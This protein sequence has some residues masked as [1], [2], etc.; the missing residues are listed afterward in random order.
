MSINDI[1]RGNTKRYKF[2]FSTTAGVIDITGWKI[3]FTAKSDID[4]LDVNAEIQVVATAGDDGLD[5]PVNG[6]M[7]LTLTSTDTDQ[8]PD[9]YHYEFTRVIPG[10]TPD[11]VQLDTGTFSILKSVIENAV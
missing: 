5:D 2:T 10:G 8:D 3:Y 9:S 1:P 4:E 11:V 7:Y 6:L